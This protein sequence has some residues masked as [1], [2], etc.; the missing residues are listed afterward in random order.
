MTFQIA[1]KSHR[2]K[3]DTKIV[4]PTESLLHGHN[5]NKKKKSSGRNSSSCITEKD[6]Q[7]MVPP[8]YN[9]SNWIPNLVEYQLSSWEEN[10]TTSCDQTKGHSETYTSK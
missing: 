3:E 4:M 9:T 1:A 5:M 2:A 6:G 7:W 10:Y 8:Q